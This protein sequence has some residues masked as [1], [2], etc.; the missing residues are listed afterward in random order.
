MEQLWSPWRIEYIL[1]EKTKECVFCKVFAADVS[2][3]KDYL[4]LHRGLH[5]AVIMNLYPYNNGHLMVIPYEH[6]ETFEDLSIEAM[7]ETMV[8]MNKCV[9]ALRLAMGAQGFNVG[10]NM[11]KAAGAGID[12]HVH[13]HV[14]PRW[15]GDTNFITTLG[16]TRCIPQSLSETYEQ[17]KVA[18]EALDT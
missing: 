9:A 13:M 1:S 7:A 4:I 11:G 2:Q 15:I 16:G 8:L 10:V 5:N 3:D 14:L 18:W 17:I 6:R 12:E